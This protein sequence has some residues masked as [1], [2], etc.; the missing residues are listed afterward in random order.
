[1]DSVAL[2]LFRFFSRTRQKAGARTGC[3]TAPAPARVQLCFI[4]SG[5]QANNSMLHRKVFALGH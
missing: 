5:V 3:G 4:V 2:A 1:M